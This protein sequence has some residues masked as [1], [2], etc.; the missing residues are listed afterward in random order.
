M[1]I[2]SIETENFRMSI[3]SDNKPEIKAQTPMAKALLKL[4][5]VKN[6]LLLTVNTSPDEIL[7]AM[8]DLEASVTKLAAI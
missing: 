8:A 2:K 1:K 7:D 4:R 5:K 3:N 6:P